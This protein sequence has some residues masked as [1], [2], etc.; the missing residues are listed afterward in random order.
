MNHSEVVDFLSGYLDR[1]KTVV[2]ERLAKISEVFT[3]LLDRERDIVV[4]RLGSFET[5]MRHERKGF[6]P[7]K[8]K[9]MILPRKRVVTFHTGASLRHH[10]NETGE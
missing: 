3:E 4:P 6:D 9:Y 7:G 10:V 2:R 8:K 1:P 5:R